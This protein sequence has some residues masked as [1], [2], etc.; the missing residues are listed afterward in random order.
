MGYERHVF[1]DCFQYGI[2]IAFAFRED[3]PCRIWF[4]GEERWATVDRKGW[5]FGW[6]FGRT[7]DH[8]ED[9]PAVVYAN[10]AETWYFEGWVHRED[11]PAM[12]QPNGSTVGYY[13]YGH[14]FSYEDWLELTER[15]KRENLDL[16]FEVQE[17]NMK[18]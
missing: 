9:G 2:G 8:R 18:R 5:N 13:L 10:G 17:R 14:R 11:G 3:G 6:D 16:H 12:I 15:C 7:H 4:D 1:E